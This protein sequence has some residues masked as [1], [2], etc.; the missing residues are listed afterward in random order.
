G[1]MP[2]RGVVEMKPVEDDAWL[3]ARTEQVTRYFNT[4]RLVIVTNLRDFLII[5]EAPNGQPEKRESF[6]LA[7]DAKS[8]W[9]LVSTPRKS[10]QQVGRAFGQ[11]LKR[12]LTQSVALREPRD[13]AWFLAAY[14]RDALQ[15]VEAESELSGL[16]S[17]KTALEDSLGMKF[18]GEKGEHF[19]RSTLVQTL[20][21]GVFSSW[22]LW[23]QMTPPTTKRY[24][25]RP[26]I[27]HLLETYRIVRFLTLGYSRH[28]QP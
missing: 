7:K 13:L 26:E 8:F 17:I 18:E 28:I 14:A 23:A 2:E 20:F 16:A 6:R 4:Y 11:Y 22:V 5:G 1:Q 21:Y 10:A 15:R 24:E 12:G 25:C 27:C 3:T 9:D 19:F